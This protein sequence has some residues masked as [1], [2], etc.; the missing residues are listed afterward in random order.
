[1][2]EAIVEKKA[3]SSCTATCGDRGG[4]LTED[5]GGAGGAHTL[6]NWEALTRYPETAIWRSTTTGPSASFAA[7]QWGRNDWMFFSN[8]GGKT[9][10]MLRVFAA[11][12]QR[13]GVDP[14]A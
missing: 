12:W 13:I 10:S 3:A 7:W 8:A 2:I 11:L 5:L 14:Y 4:S 1:M 9:A 6:K